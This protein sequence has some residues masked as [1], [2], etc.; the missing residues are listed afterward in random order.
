MESN[1]LWDHPSTT[2]LAYVKL[3]RSQL[4]TY[5]HSHTAS[6]RKWNRYQMEEAPLMSWTTE[7]STVR[8]FWSSVVLWFHV[9]DFKAPRGAQKNLQ[10]ATEAVV[11]AADP[12]Q[13]LKEDLPRL[14][15]QPLSLPLSVGSYMAWFLEDNF[16]PIQHHFSE[17]TLDSLHPLE[18]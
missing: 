13:C 10:S 17:P 9:V 6:Q 16:C 2:T 3:R 7:W 4:H 15:P 12:H 18:M 14:G 11:P 8:L 1:S 5:T